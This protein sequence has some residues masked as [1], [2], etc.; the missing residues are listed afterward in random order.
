MNS[1]VSLN[2]LVVLPHGCESEGT[3]SRRSNESV[4]L[5]GLKTFI[6]ANC[7]QASLASPIKG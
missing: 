4:E 3:I 5:A 2:V 7:D 1:S 6:D